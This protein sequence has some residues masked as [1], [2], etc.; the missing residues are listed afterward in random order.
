[1]ALTGRRLTLEEFL[2]QPVEEASMVRWFNVNGLSWDVI[3]A[4]GNHHS[5]HRLAIEDLIN[6]KNR[7]KADWYNDHTFIVL[8]L[9][10]LV[11][12]QDGED[13]E[14][15]EESAIRNSSQKATIIAVA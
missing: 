12:L 7:T 4:L 6:T 13:C 1:M 8:A 15:D 14:S 10:K 9:Q 5:L 2:E 3:R 11:R